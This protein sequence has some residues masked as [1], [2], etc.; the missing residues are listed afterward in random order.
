VDGWI[1][2]TIDFTDGEGE[3]GE[4]GE[5]VGSMRCELRWQAEDNSLQVRCS[6][7]TNLK[8]ISRVEIRDVNS[9]SDFGM[10]FKTLFWLIIYLIVGTVYYSIF[11]SNCIPEMLPEVKVS[12]QSEQVDT[13]ASV[14]MAT[15]ATCADWMVQFGGDAGTFATGDAWTGTVTA[16]Y[17]LRTSDGTAVC[18]TFN[19][20]CTKT[21]ITKADTASKFDC[22][23]DGCT[24]REEALGV[25]TSCTA[26]WAALS[27]LEDGPGA[28]QGGAAAADAVR[29]MQAMLMVAEG[30]TAISLLAA[31]FHYICSGSI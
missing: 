15:T 18:S 30:C 6:G 31:L 13:F 20:T 5:Q 10:L 2:E 25:A 23:A 26:L 3:E 21:H 9:F 12:S 16:R 14:P 8:D 11:F 28:E 19:G 1:P 24:A 4:E 17:E 27:G 29:K 7:F 22:G